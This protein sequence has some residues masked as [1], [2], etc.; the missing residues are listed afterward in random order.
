M[1]YA[2][3]AGKDVLGGT[4]RV[5]RTGVWS[6]H[7]ETDADD[8]GA[9]AGPLALTLGDG[10][11]TWRCS[12]VRGSLA[13]GKVELWVAG[14]AAG[15][16][17]SLPGQSYTNVSAAVPIADIVAGAREQLA[18]STHRHVLSQELRAWSRMAGPAS[19][20]LDRL[21]DALGATWRVLPDGTLWV[22]DET[23]PDAPAFDYEVLAEHPAAARWEI[24]SIEAYK[25]LPGTRFA[26]APVEHVEHKI[27][28]DALR[29]NVWFALT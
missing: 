17:R 28:T 3:L 24:A 22:G 26:S 10:A 6:A 5:P 14:G 15:L 16:A 25:L 1:A 7:L 18:P 20:Q 2:S 21:V 12:V 13:F 11:V 27:A 29:S 8:I 19:S 23:W 9:F 4:I